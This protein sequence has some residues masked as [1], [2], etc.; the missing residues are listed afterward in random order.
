VLLLWQG[1]AHA[2]GYNL[3]RAT[4]TGGPYTPIM[5]GAVG[6]S[7]AD[8]G[9][10]NGTTYYYILTATN[11]LGE[12]A[13]SP[14]VRATPVPSVG[15]KLAASFVAAQ[16]TVSWP[17]DYVGWILQTNTAGLANPAAWGDVPD[18]R[19]HSQMTFP[20]G[21]PNSPAEFFR[22]RHP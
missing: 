3:K 13:S 17:S 1:V 18:S 8:S 22:L 14:E 4:L 21:S 9:L 2:T 12:S 19:S 20:A 11:H 16:I 7:F 10:T 6:A 15:S 5:S